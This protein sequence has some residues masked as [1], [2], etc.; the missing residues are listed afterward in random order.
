[1]VRL[2]AGV[3]DGAREDAGEEHESST[4]TR[5]DKNARTSARPAAAA[6]SSRLTTR[7]SLLFRA[8]RA[9]CDAASEAAEEARKAELLEFLRCASRPIMGKA[10]ARQSAGQKALDLTKQMKNLEDLDLAA[11]VRLNSAELKKRGVPTRDRKRLLN[12]ADKYAQGYRHD[13]RLGK[14]AWKGWLPPYKLDPERMAHTG[15][16]L[17]NDHVDAASSGPLGMAPPADADADAEVPTVEEAGPALRPRTCLS[18]SGPRRRR[19][20]TRPPPRRC[21]TRS[22]SSA[23]TRRR[24]DRGCR[25]ESTD[26]EMVYL[27][28][29]RCLKPSTH[30]HTYDD[31]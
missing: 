29:S 2:L 14:H 16:R 22:P 18:Q 19:R 30:A 17:Y 6:S 13:G 5:R 31:T 28:S 23:S 3:G 10:K 20:P 15:N 21:A 8:S 11:V 1:M 9:L 12:Y 24:F 7:P 26:D 25:V 4:A 27:F